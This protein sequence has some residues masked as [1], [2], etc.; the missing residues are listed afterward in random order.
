MKSI[1]RLALSSLPLG[2]ALLIPAAAAHAG[3]W[4]N[5]DNQSPLTVNFDRV[6]CGWSGGKALLK[7]TNDGSPPKSDTFTL[8]ANKQVI[9]TQELDPGD[10]PARESVPLDGDRSVKISVTSKLTGTQI[11]FKNVTNHCRRGGGG[12]D[13]RGNGW[14][15]RWNRWDHRRL[16]FTGPPADLWG[17]LATGGGLLLTGGIVWWYSSIWPRRGYNPLAR[18]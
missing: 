6:D 10:S 14:G 8:K 1:A 7:I 4:P 3:D 16:P 13:H 9:D 15:D 12:W 18:S 11:F 2:A 5:H 17:K